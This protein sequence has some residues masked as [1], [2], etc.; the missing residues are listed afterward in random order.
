MDIEAIL[1]QYGVVE[2]LVLTEEFSDHLLERGTFEKHN[3]SL[4]EIVEVH[5]RAPKYFLNREGRRAPIIMLGTTDSGRLLCVPLEPS[6]QLGI[7]MPVTA[8]EANS[9]DVERYMGGQS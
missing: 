2:E 6:G 5:E 1:D 3:V 8:F 9:H 4:A 7:W